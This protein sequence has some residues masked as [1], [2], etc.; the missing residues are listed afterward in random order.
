[1]IG[2]GGVDVDVDADFVQGLNQC[3]TNKIESVLR[4]EWTS[5]V[6]LYYYLFYYWD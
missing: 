6:E 3:L 4:S 1:L 2:G 5:L